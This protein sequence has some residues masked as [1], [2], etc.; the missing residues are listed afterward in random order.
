MKARGLS[1]KDVIKKS[2]LIDTAFSDFIINSFYEL[3]PSSGINDRIPWDKIIHFLGFHG[4][5]DYYV[6]NICIQCI[7]NLEIVYNKH[8]QSVKKES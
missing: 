5:N 1:T 7:R 4:F 3:Y 6:L 8:I 2:G